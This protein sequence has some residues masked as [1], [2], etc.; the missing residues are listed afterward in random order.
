MSWFGPGIA[1]SRQQMADFDIGRESLC[2]L[3][4]AA[5]D[6]LRRLLSQAGSPGDLIKSVSVQIRLYEDK[7]C[8]RAGCL[9]V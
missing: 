1:E 8:L 4:L 5:T 6:G 2:R 7:P 3:I 9:I